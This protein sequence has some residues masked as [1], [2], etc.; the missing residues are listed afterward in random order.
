MPLAMRN[1]AIAQHRDKAR[2]RRVRGGTGGWDRPKTVI[3]EGDFVLVK[4]QTLGG[5][6]IATNPHILRVLRLKE[7]GV[8]VLQGQDGSCVEEQVKN[9]APCSLPI[10]DKKNYPKRFFRGETL[11]CRECGQR[12]RADAMVICDKCQEGYHI[13]CLE[14]PLTEIPVGG[15]VCEY[16]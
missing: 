9:V 6:D 10:K 2:F 13:W 5:L 15:W 11:H 1:L 8:V 16:H 3:K 12:N 7:S 4:R 14:H